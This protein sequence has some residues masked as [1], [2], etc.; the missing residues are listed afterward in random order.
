MPS[1]LVWCLLGHLKCS[2]CGFESCRSYQGVLVGI[3]S[4]VKSHSTCLIQQWVCVNASLPEGLYLKIHHG[5]NP[6]TI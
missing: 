6:C 4:A 2:G 1:I 5:W 3:A